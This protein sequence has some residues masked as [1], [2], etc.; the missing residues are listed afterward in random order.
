MFGVHPGCLLGRVG[1][2]QDVLGGL[3]GGLEA[4]VDLGAVDQRWP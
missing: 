4:R 1:T 3:Q 2:L